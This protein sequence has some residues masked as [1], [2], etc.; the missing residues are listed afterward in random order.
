MRFSVKSI[1]IDDIRISIDDLLE[2]LWIVRRI[3]FEIRVLNEDVP[4]AC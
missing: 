3:I 1:S 2:Q 4:V